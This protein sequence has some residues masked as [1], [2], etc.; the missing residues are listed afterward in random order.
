MCTQKVGYD[1]EF[2]IFISWLIAQG[3]KKRFSAS[4]GRNCT[5]TSQAPGFPIEEQW[6]S[7]SIFMWALAYLSYHH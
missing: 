4:N 5:N 6:I 2:A 1:S 3:K 7:E